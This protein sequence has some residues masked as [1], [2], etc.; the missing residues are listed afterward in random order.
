MLFLP[1]TGLVSGPYIKEIMDLPQNRYFILDEN[2]NI[3]TTND[4]MEWA[5]FLETDKRILKHTRKYG[6]LVSTVFLGLDHSWEMG[7]HQPILFETMVFGGKFNDYQERYCTYN[8]ALAGH[9][10]IC[11]FAF[12]WWWVYVFKDIVRR[13]RRVGFWRLIKFIGEEIQKEKAK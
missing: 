11:C 9:E 12:K 13:I 7:P 6:I 3:K 5:R 1:G 8:D 4:L 2:N 10:L